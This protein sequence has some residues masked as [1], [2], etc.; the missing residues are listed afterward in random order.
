HNEDCSYLKLFIRNGA[1]LRH[2]YLTF[3]YD[4]KIFY[5][6]KNQYVIITAHI[7]NKQNSFGGV[8]Q[9]IIIDSISES[10]SE[11]SEHFFDN[12][13]KLGF[14][15]PKSY[16]KCYVYGK[17]IHIFEKIILIG[18]NLLIRTILTSQS[19]SNIVKKCEYQI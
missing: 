17:V 3:R 18:L 10:Q 7:E 6:S 9:F 12:Q 13:K 15:H 4:P 2:T 19:N 11:L 16:A 14:S 8:D 1:G 5:I